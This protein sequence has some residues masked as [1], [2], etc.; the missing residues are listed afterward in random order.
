MNRASS[1]IMQT[2]NAGKEKS[3]LWLDTYYFKLTQHYISNMNFNVI[4]TSEKIRPK[5]VDIL[6]EFQFVRISELQFRFTCIRTPVSSSQPVP[7]GYKLQLHCSI[8]VFDKDPKILE[9]KSG[10]VMIFQRFF[11]NASYLQKLPSS[12]FNKEFE[13]KVV[14]KMIEY[15]CALTRTQFY[16]EDEFRKLREKYFNYESVLKDLS[17]ILNMQRVRNVFTGKCIDVFFTFLFAYE[18]F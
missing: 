11:L 16:Q 6:L 5:H 4:W 8:N 10:D 3:V 9:I 17:Y 14:I 15:D 12:D 13:L 1:I 2:L 7:D 18:S